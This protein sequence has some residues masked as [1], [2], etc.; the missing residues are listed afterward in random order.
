MAHIV[1]RQFFPTAALHFVARLLPPNSTDCAAIEKSLA[2]DHARDGE[3]MLAFGMNGVQLPLLN[4]FPIR[5][6]V[7]GWYSTYWVKH[8]NSIEVLARPDD[9][10]WMA[11]AY[12]IPT[13]PAA[14]VAPGAKDFPTTP[15]NRMIPRSWVTNVSEGQAIAWAPTIPLGGIAMGGDR[16]VAAVDVSAD[17]GQSWHP[18]TLGP[19]HGKYSFRRWDA[20][21][22]LGTPGRIALMSRCRNVS[23][24]VQAATPVWNP[25]GFMRGNIET[26]VVSVA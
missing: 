5:L 25:S 7:P 6:V 17:G 11:K 20:Q 21:V 19:D 22:P 18:A 16:G 15:I 10:Y 23:G 13:T 12:K 8:L 2:I 9:R 24:E 3:V 4:G 1:V 26:T 14:D